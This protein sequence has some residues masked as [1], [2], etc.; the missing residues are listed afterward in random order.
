MGALKVRRKISLK[1][2][3]VELVKPEIKPNDYE[4]ALWGNF[5]PC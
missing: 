2:V 3:L 5:K 1:F 4:G